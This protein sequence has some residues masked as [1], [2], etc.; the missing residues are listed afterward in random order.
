[1]SK[2]PKAVMARPIDA[3]T[4]T[5]E[6]MAVR[7]NRGRFKDGLAVPVQ[8]RREE[9]TGALARLLDTEVFE[10]GPVRSIWRWMRCMLRWQ[11]TV[12]FILRCC[13]QKSSST[14]QVKEPTV[15]SALSQNFAAK[16]RNVGRSPRTAADALVGLGFSSLGAAGPCPPRTEGV[17]RGLE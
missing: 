9:L 17:R 5:S 2:S 12:I 6:P 14:R 10:H 8:L 13:C 4:P 15:A 1:V 11:A 7:P 16:V 3:G